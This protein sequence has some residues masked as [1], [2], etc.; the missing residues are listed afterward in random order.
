MLV[1]SRLSTWSWSVDLTY[2]LVST[3]CASCWLA[4]MTPRTGVDT[5]HW[6]AVLMKYARGAYRVF[7]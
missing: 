3:L 1:S 7:I 2:D 5:G 6:P 4:V